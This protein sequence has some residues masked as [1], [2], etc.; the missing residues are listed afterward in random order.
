[1]LNPDQ[2]R[3]AEHPVHERQRSATS[4]ISSA[5]PPASTSPTTA[6]SRIATITLNLEGVT[7]EQALQQIM[8]A[9]QLFYKVLN[10][11]TIIVAADTT[12]KRTQDEEQVIRTFFLSHA[13]ATETA[14]MLTGIVRVAGVAIQPTIVANKTEQ[15]HHRPRHRLGGADRRADDRPNDKP[16]AEV[17]VDVQILEVNRERAKQYGLNLTD[18]AIGGVVLARSRAGTGGAGRRGQRTR[19]AVQPQHISQ[20][21]STADFYL[22]VPA[23]VDALPRERLAHQ[24]ARQAA[25]ARRRRPE[26][27]AQSRRGRAGAEHHLHADRRRR[28]RDSAA[29]VVRAIAPSASSSR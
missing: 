13:D 11:R 3:S 20:G 16:R 4:S 6:T 5:T 28:R 27:D 22:S 17:I 7:L 14:Q 15:H 12:Q 9:N 24:D 26:A 18:Y 1:M 19:H 23:A 8:I 29:D 21:V 10:E 25:A 2:P